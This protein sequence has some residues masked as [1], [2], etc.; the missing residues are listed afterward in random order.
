MEWRRAISECVHKGHDLVITD[1]GMRP[2]EGKWSFVIKR[3][4]RRCKYTT[5]DTVRDNGK[6]D[7][8]KVLQA[9]NLKYGLRV[10]TRSEATEDK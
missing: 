1:L 7:M 3:R 10:L 4:C 6:T 2:Y 9:L 5:I 8:A